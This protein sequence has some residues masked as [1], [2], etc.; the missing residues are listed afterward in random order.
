[1]SYAT[2]KI[3]ESNNTNKAKAL[4][5]VSEPHSISAINMYDP[6]GLESSAILYIINQSADP[7][8][9][10]GSFCPISLFRVNDYLEN[11]TKNIACSLYRI[12]VFIR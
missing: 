2:S 4:E 5:S 12:I 10:D 11:N 7:Q 9:W 6:H 1:M 8:L 3:E